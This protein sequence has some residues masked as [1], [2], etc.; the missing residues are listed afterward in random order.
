VA[1]S[2]GAALLFTLSG[3]YYFRR[4]EEGFADII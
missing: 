2:I 4:A 1:A 3:I